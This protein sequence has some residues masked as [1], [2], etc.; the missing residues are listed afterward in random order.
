M[1]LA[2]GRLHLS[3]VRLLVPHLT[4][5]NYQTVLDEASHRSKREVEQIVAR[6]QP[7][8]DV[9]S[10]I[11]KLPSPRAL[12]QTAQPL[13][14]VSDSVDTVPAQTD[15]VAERGA[16]PAPAERT[17]AKPLAPGRYKVQ[18]TV[19]EETYQ[20]LRRVQVLLRHR[21]PK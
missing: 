1:L 18:F 7:R 8:P 21:L 20:K 9:P 12:R 6:L 14:R 15:A 5:A 10:S 2:D 13:M 17:N 11:R 3:A 19:T 16:R 4:E